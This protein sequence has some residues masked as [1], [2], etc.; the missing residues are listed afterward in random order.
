MNCW[1]YH[2][3]RNCT[4]RGRCGNCGQLSHND[5][6]LCNIPPQCINCAGPH[7]SDDTRCALRP[8]RRDGAVSRPSRAARLEARRIGQQ[9]YRRTN[10]E[11]ALTPLEVDL[12]S[13]PC[14]AYI[15][16]AKR[17][18]SDDIAT[19]ALN[20]TGNSPTEQLAQDIA[21]TSNAAPPLN[22]LDTDMSDTILVST[23]VVS[24]THE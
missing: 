17:P 13:S 4:R 7:R 22:S 12:R 24:A 21:R 3:A 9:L 15:Q 1:G 19:E 8:T 14:P 10:P 20:S 23:S 6:N 18:R 2:A 11:R 5:N 16:R